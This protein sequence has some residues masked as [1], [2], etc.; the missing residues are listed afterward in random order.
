MKL[1]SKDI[2]GVIFD[3]DG[4]LLDTMPIWQDVCA[5][6]LRELGIEPDPDLNEKVF[7]MTLKEGC[8][9]TKEHYKL[10]KTEQE[11]EDGILEMIRRFYYFEAP[12]K[13]GVAALVKELAS[14][15]IPMV[16]A[17]TGDEDLA[18][19]ALERLGLLKYFTKLL[20]CGSL[21]T[22][23]REP[24]VF[25]TAK[26]ILEEAMNTSAGNASELSEEV[27][28][29]DIFV[30]EDSLTAIKTTKAAGFTVVGL[31]YNACEKDW[32]EV[33]RNADY[34][35]TSLEACELI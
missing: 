7:S 3:I 4:T 35:F 9:F 2:K 32:E 28:A 24:L 23:K 25:L 14:R 20:T 13:P 1:V 27:A 8:H 33:Q 16:L 29:G 31:Y 17:T 19:H 15:H 30:F 6:Y 21:G 18:S 34:S 26:K 22:S 5:R 11:I 10:E 12:A